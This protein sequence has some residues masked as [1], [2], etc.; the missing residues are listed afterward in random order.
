MTTDGT[1]GGTSDDIAGGNEIGGIG[2]AEAVCHIGSISE[3]GIDPG[4][5]IVE[6]TTP[7]Q[8]AFTVREGHGRPGTI[9]GTIN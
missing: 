1:A 2:G 4:I 5:G 9:D 7:R 3:C 6:D 8:G